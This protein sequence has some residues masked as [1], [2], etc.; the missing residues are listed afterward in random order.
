MW[1]T[2]P[3]W[4]GRIEVVSAAM[5][6]NFVWGLFLSFSFSQ[7][8]CPLPL[9]I[10]WKNE[11]LVTYGPKI[12]FPGKFS[13]VVPNQ[14]ILIAPCRLWLLVSLWPPVSFLGFSIQL[15][16]GVPLEPL[17]WQWWILCALFLLLGPVCEGI[18]RLRKPN[19]FGNLCCGSNGDRKC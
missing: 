19:V 18:K 13:L 7:G 4:K 14:P 2:S 10:K 8:Q 1:F 3:G 15:K 9:V 6:P 12:C 16:I 17:A 11:C 5:T